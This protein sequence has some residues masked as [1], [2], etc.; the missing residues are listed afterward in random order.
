MK[1]KLYEEVNKYDEEIKLCEDWPMWLK[2]THKGYRFHY[3]DEPLVMYRKYSASTWGQQ[4]TERK[5]IIT[6]GEDIIKKKYIYPNIGCIHKYMLKLDYYARKELNYLSSNP[7]PSPVKVY[8][9]ETISK[10][11]KPYIRFLYKW[12]DRKLKNRIRNNE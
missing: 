6:N 7:K 12:Y 2:V 1:K 4:T 11:Y 10:I 5:Y 8:I 9:L 3:I